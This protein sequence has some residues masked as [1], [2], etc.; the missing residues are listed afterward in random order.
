[1]LK[2]RC[3]A[4]DIQNGTKMLLVAA[5][6]HYSDLGKSVICVMAGHGTVCNFQEYPAIS[7]QL[8]GTSGS[9]GK[10]SSPMSFMYS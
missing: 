5:K 8:H 10:V 9:V 2:V 7:Y 4:Q 6:G 3:G 1:M